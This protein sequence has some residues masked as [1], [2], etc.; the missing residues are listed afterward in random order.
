MKP[1]VFDTYTRTIITANRRGIPVVI[2]MGNDGHQT[3][4]A[5]GND[6]FAFS[7]GATDVIDRTAG[8]S[9]GRTQIIN[10]SRYINP[11]YL[12]LVYSKPD[13][14]APG[15]AVYSCIPGNKYDSW[16][17]T[18]MA[19]PHVAGA[20]ALLLSGTKIG[21]VDRSRRAYL[22][23]DILTATV[24]ELG[25]SGQDQRYGF[26]RIDALRAIGY[27]RHLGYGKTT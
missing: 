4:G 22:I 27:A 8:F 6:F 26:G 9:G 2:A 3:S 23:Q 18:S 19:T 25:E 10:R 7:V 17:G 1:D 14:S 16:N 21:S 24:D 15:V 11:Q 13:V 5:P 12:P 20:I